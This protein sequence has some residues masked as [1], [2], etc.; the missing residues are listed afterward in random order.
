MQTDRLRPGRRRQVLALVEGLESLGHPAVLAANDD[1]EFERLAAEGL[2]FVSIAP[3]NEFDVHTG[4]QLARIISDAKPAVVHAHD[5]MGVSLAAMALQMQHDV[6]PAPVLLASRRIDHHLKRQ[7]FSRW[8]YRRVNG[9][10]AA[11]AVIRDMLVEDGVAAEDVVVV[12]DGVNISAID[13]VPAAD[14][15]ATFWLPRG[16]PVVGN[17]AALLPHKGQK[18]LVAAA[19]RVVRKVPDAR[20]VIIGEGELRHVLEQQVK[21]LGLE[22]HLLLAGYR[23]D[24]MALVK[25]L[26]VFV[27]SS[28]AEGLG[29]AV[30]EAMA[31]R[32]PVV[33]TRAGGI[34]ETIVDG[35]TGLLVPPHD[36]AALADAIVRLLED[37]LLRGRLAEA[38]RARVA[39]EFSVE[40]R[41]ERTLD[42]Y[43][44]FLGRQ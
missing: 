26:D 9:F 29:T 39:T 20:F 43:R 7:A 4:W 36:D 41:I 3:K 13:K 8:K 15:H 12:H 37:D 21:H 11:S 42:A 2:R 22:R 10:L 5:P 19:A 32:R 1:G 28:L 34:P 23:S 33:A 18:Y 35:E 38:G 30:L 16:A 27:V 40:R 25:S 14:V 44:L 17:V 24:A 31:C 6:T